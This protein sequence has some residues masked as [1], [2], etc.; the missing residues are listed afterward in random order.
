ML[1]F[2]RG[3]QTESVIEVYFTL[4]KNDSANSIIKNK[5]NYVEP[6]ILESGKN[7]VIL[8]GDAPIAE[9]D[10]V[11]PPRFSQSDII[12]NKEHGVIRIEVTY[13]GKDGRL[14]IHY[15]LRKIIDIF[16]DRSYTSKVIEIE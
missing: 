5:M 9:S 2:N 15:Y 12:R 16:K 1:F 13:I 3:N 6:F 10:S 4:V 11:N 7:N 14:K 8:F